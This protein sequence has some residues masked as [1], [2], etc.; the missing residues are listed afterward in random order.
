MNSIVPLFFSFLLTCGLAQASFLQNNSGLTPDDAVTYGLLDNG[1]R[2]AIM[3][4]Q[5]PPERISLRLLIEAGSLMETDEQ[6][7]LAHFLEHLAF[8]GS[9]NYPPGEL[10]EFLQRMGMGFGAHTNAHTSFD[11]TVYKLEL[12]KNSESYLREG[13]QVMRDYAGGLLLLPEEIERERGV[14]LAE[15][16]DRD[17]AF[18]R[19]IE[20]WFD[21]AFPESLLSQR[22]PIGSEAVIAEAGR[23]RFVEFYE[24]WYTADRI[25]VVVVGDVE[26]AE[27]E[28]LISEYFSALPANPQAR[29]DPE[30]GPLPERGLA[31]FLQ[32][33]P[34]LSSTTVLLMTLSPVQ[35]KE[36]TLARRLQQLRESIAARILTRRLDILAKQ[37]GSPISEGKASIY[38]FLNYAELAE[39]EVTC[40]PENWQAALEMTEQEL[41][42]ALQHGF[43]EAEVAEARANLLQGF[44]QAVR[45][46]STRKS[47]GL[48]SAIADH[49]SS[50]KVFTSPEEELKIA[51][52]AMEGLTP[53]RV[54]EA[55]QQV[56]AR[57][58]RLVFISGNL[59][60]EDAEATISEVYEQSMD[61]PVEAP[62]ETEEA[63]FAYTD[64]GTPGKVISE[65]FHQDL[66]IHQAVFENG[67]R[68][69]FKQTDFTASEVRVSINFGGGELAMAEAQAGIHLFANST[70]I[71]GGLEA[72]SFDELQ[73]ILAGKTVGASFEVGSDRFYL[74]GSTIAEEALL[75]LQLCTAYLT[76]PGYRLE[77]A[78][79]AREGF[80][81]LY[82]ELDHTVEGVFRDRVAKILSGGSFRFGFPPKDALLAFTMEDVRQWLAQP[83]AES[84]LEVN[85]V[86]DI[87]YPTAR[88]Y[89]A[90]TL[91]TL[92]DRL[93]KPEAF[94]TARNS[95]HFP[96]GEERKTL[97]YES[98]IPRSIAAV[99]WS[100]DDFW[101]VDRT[102]RLNLLSSILRDRLRVEVR[103]KLGEGYSP[104]AASRPS[105]TYKGFGYLMAVNFSD[106]DKAAE[107]S[108]IIARIANELVASGIT[109]DELERARKPIVNSIKEIQRENA[110]WLDRVLSGASV[111]PQLLDFA[112]SLPTAFEAITQQELNQLA[113]TYLAGNKRLEV[114]IRPEGNAPLPA[115]PPA[116]QDKPLDAD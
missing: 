111:Y 114:V 51:E 24:G 72:H 34:E 32:S 17:S 1:V 50:D 116:S 42:R 47:S 87:D 103:E 31:T 88:Q 93:E 92:P 70:F 94:S 77:A 86:G 71:Q 73:R 43:T 62:S 27:A 52:M 3:P 59:E 35:D 46:A 45:E 84:Y 100:T 112:R 23:D 11:E 15:K 10:I 96:E 58:D 55:L 74:G 39:I 101:D 91:G 9:E 99:F 12:P 18:Y 90:A 57:P 20:A 60:L 33:E 61:V 110:Y 54:Q 48:S 36:D 102:R 38:D 109:A 98:E 21:F 66:G 44:R 64:F 106:P 26:T 29:P 82:K 28:Q 63:R 65:T 79:L 97:T 95:V 5:E 19:S 78:R 107:V 6:A 89:V 76:A 2:Y 81:Q 105:E 14:V 30:L 25:A 108:Q 56:W 113:E 104:F 49:I 8:N 80:E 67:V 68:F 53:D 40:R 16:R 37:E 75:Q 13:L 41:R 69:N 115:A 7:G 4:N 85:I 83:L 22:L